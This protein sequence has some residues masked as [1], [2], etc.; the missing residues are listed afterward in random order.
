[1][2]LL[3][4]NI[5][6][7]WLPL[8]YEQMTSKTL[9]SFLL[10]SVSLRKILWS[11]NKRKSTLVARC[12]NLGET[13]WKCIPGVSPWLTRSLRSHKE[14]LEPV[15]GT[16]AGGLEVTCRM[17][18]G[19]TVKQEEIGH[20]QHLGRFLTGKASTFPHCPRAGVST[21]AVQENH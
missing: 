6:R 14:N 9:L 11:F 16:D 3:I 4:V 19:P 2:E 5:L 1:M 12:R 20:P 15:K 8:K 13:K 21:L 10:T 18:R 7:S 17:G